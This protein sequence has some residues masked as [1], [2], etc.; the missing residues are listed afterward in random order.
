[1]KKLVLTLVSFLSLSSFAQNS[2][3]LYFINIDNPRIQ[4]PLPVQ[5]NTAYIGSYDICFVGNGWAAKTALWNHVKD[6]IEKASAYV[7][8]DQNAN[9]IFYGYVDTK[10]T[11]EGASASECRV[12]LRANICRF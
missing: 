5:G 10:C 2:E 3:R 9:V 8:F 7:R 11:D 6:D 1:M 4:S 12:D